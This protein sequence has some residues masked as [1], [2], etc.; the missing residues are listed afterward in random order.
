MVAFIYPPSDFGVEELETEN[1]EGMTR[2]EL[3]T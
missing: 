3:L 1:S 2:A